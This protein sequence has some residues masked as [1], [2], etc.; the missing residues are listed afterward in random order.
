VQTKA[1]LSPGP[2]GC[3]APVA[4]AQTAT[5]AALPATARTGDRAAAGDGVQKER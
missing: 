4:L 1:P 2:G 5:P 3:G